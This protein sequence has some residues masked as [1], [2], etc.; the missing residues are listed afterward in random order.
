MADTMRAYRLLD[1]Q[2][3]DFDEVPVPVPGPGQVRVRVGGV[4]LC[5]SDVI[6]LEAPAGLLPYDLPFTL[7]HEIAGWIDA[8]G[9]GTS[10]VALDE[11]VAVACMSPCG[12]CRWC[13]RGQDNYCVDTWHGR[14]FGI[15][16]GLAEYLVVDA[17]QVV[18]LGDLD[19]RIAGPL[20]DAGATSYHAVKKVLPKIYDDSTVVVI[21]V[22][23]LGAYGVQWL[24]MLTTARIIAVEAKPERIK[25]AVDL[26]AHDVVEAGEG[27]SKRLAAAIG[28][29]GADAILDFVGS[30]ATIRASFRNAA[31]AGAIALVGQGFG[32]AEVR[33]GAMAHDC[34]LFNPQGATIAEL[35]EVIALAKTGEVV[36]E[37]EHFAFDD[38]PAAYER[39]EA[40]TL[41]GRAVVLPN[42]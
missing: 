16:G 29:G 4:G 17:G 20:T 31:K 32:S 7:G 30:D 1:W 37:V 14:G 10:N 9:D 35:H 6:F 23:G 13:R 34:D 19:P 22:G 2:R 15:D 24:R 21:G 41:N 26:G 25:A 18:P 40:G 28:D 5:H 39:L 33:Y 38:T 11:P 42:G 8:I 27:L 12:D 3:A 36:V